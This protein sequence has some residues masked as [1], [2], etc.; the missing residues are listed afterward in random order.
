MK[1][2]GASVD[3]KSTQE[4]EKNINEEKNKEY[5]EQ[6]TQYMPENIEE[7]H[8]SHAM[9]TYTV[10]F[11]TIG[12]QAIFEYFD[13][14]GIQSYEAERKDFMQWLTDEEEK[15]VL[16]FESKMREKHIKRMESKEKNKQK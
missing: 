7:I 4:K 14:D 11:Y 9:C 12:K 16:G 5:E 2:I 15:K 10:S 6:T 3:A 8:I 1:N 13:D